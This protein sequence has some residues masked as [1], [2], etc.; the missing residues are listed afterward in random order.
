[1]KKDRNKEAKEK[2]ELIKYIKTPELRLGQAISNF[3]REKGFEV[4]L[5]DENGKEVDLF[6]YERN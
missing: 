3:Y 5:R 1:M 4:I 2:Q 6:Y